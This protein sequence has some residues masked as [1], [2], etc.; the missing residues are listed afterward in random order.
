MRQ[1]ITKAAIKRIQASK[2]VPVRQSITKAAITRIQARR[3]APVPP[4]EIS[5][6]A[7]KWKKPE[8]TNEE[9]ELTRKRKKQETDIHHQQRKY[10]SKRK[11]HDSQV[12]ECTPWGPAP[13]TQLPECAWT[14]II[15]FLST[16]GLT[17]P[18]L[19]GITLQ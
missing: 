1:S 11:K 9:P 14:I 10:A 5:M 13:A 17:F 12:K 18:S 7:S 16:Q 19:C 15:P 3:S 6:S 8:L 4:E 2:S